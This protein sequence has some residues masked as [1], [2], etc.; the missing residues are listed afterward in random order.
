MKNNIEKAISK[1]QELKNS[2]KGT[3]ILIITKGIDV[4][5]L[6]LFIEKTGHLYYGENYTKELKKWVEIKEKYPNVK[7]SFVG[8]FQTGNIRNI[9]KICDV[10]EGIS[11]LKDLDKI[12]KEI[13][14]QGKNV[15]CYAQ[16]NIGNESQKNG[17]K[18]N[19]LNPDMKGK[20]DGIMCIPP[21]FKNPTSFFKQMKEI[22]SMLELE[23]IS[24][25]M[26]NDYKE[27]IENGS[28]EIRIGSLIFGDNK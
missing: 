19:E 8:S 7:L 6:N 9:V 20:F 27:A 4:D 25:G 23:N 11:S 21:N 14:K 18:V 17:F 26:T 5:F 15:L 28:T 16:I 10:I 3:K 12:K 22:A 2:S 24:M 13:S 1:Y